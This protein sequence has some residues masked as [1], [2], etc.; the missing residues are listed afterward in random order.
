MLSNTSKF[1]RT[2]C[3]AA[4]AVCTIMSAAHVQGADNLGHGYVSSVTAGSGECVQSTTNGGGIQFWD[5]QA[6]G[7]Y[8]VTLSGVDDAANRGM[9]TSMDVIVHNS[10]GG[11]INVA[12]AQVLNTDGVYTFTIHLTTQCLTMPIEY[13]T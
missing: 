5:I 6:G 8:T 9:D 7:T 11:N 4:V 1:L 12:A 10:A 2:A 13:G 3:I